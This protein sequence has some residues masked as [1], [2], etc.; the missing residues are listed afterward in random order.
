MSHTL[1]VRA[2]FEDAAHA[3][4]AY[5]Q[6]QARATN[7]G[8]EGGQGT[9]YARLTHDGALV[10]MWHV[11]I[12][13]IVRDGNW[14]AY[15]TAPAWIQPAGAHDSYPALDALGDPARVTHAEALWQNSHGNGNSWA[16][17]QYGWTVVND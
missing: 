8:I 11:D 12:F 10:S 4:D 9:S 7:T 16:P 15:D 13:G 14:V 1:L 3:V 2:V 5:A 6:M 17:G